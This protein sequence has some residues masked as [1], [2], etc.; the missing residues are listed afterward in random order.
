[1]E[2]DILPLRQ[3]QGTGMSVQFIKDRGQVCLNSDK[4]KHIYK[5]VDKDSAVNIGTMTQRNGKR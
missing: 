1:M 5:K 4:T 3:Q 2:Y